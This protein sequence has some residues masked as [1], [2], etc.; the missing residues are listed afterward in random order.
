MKLT[1][2][3]LRTIIKEELFTEG[4]RVHSSTIN[5]HKVQINYSKEHDSVNINVETPDKYPFGIE[6]IPVS[7]AK[8]IVKGLNKI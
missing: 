2:S 7:V 5:G 8:E 3:Q 6:R 4:K 1:K